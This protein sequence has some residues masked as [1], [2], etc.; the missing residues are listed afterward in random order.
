M[1][2]EFVSAPLQIFL[3]GFYHLMHNML[4]LRSSMVL[5]RALP[6]AHSRKC[7]FHSTIKRHLEQDRERPKEYELRVGYGKQTSYT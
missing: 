6:L 2:R 5:K 1:T 3:L 4:I 7:L